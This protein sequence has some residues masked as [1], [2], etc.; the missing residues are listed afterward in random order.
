MSYLLQLSGG[1]T[2]E[3]FRQ[4]PRHCETETGSKWLVP[5]LRVEYDLESFTRL[6]PPRVRAP[7]S[8]GRLPF[9]DLVT[10][11]RV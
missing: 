6:R 10:A 11:V 8:T 7:R 9:L 5:A 1:L 2:D 4:K 3:L